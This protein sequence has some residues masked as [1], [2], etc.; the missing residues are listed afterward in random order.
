MEMTL[1]HQKIQNINN[2]NKKSKQNNKEEFDFSKL[3]PEG[4]R[5]IIGFFNILSKID[6]RLKNK[7]NEK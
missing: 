3:S 7:K 2:M 4:Q 6:R 1:I 5:N